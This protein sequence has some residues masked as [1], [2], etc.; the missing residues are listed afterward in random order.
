MRCSNRWKK[1][2]EVSYS[3]LMQP[4]TKGQVPQVL[5]FRVMCINVEYWEVHSL[6]LVRPCTFSSVVSFLMYLAMIPNMVGVFCHPR[7][8]SVHVPSPLGII[9]QQLFSWDSQRGFNPNVDNVHISEMRISG[10]FMWYLQNYQKSHQIWKTREKS[11]S[12]FT[13]LSACQKLICDSFSHDH[14]GAILHPG[15]VWGR[16]RRRRRWPP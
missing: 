9:R 4:I 11:D 3:S 8:L 13:V 1:N 5:N 10:S 7:P 6:L 12:D 2:G 15:V 14:L 16:Q